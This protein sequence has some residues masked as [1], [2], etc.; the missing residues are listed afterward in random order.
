[1]K[2][3]DLLAN[4]PEKCDSSCYRCLRAFGNRI[5]HRSLDRHVGVELINYLL[6]GVVPETEAGRLQL[7]A[8]LLFKDLSRLLG[9]GT[10]IECE[11]N[12]EITVDGSNY[13]APIMCRLRSKGALLVVGLSS[14][15]KE[16]YA[17]DADVRALQGQGGDIEVVVV[18]ELLARSNLPAA[19]KLVREML[20]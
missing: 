4:C 9:G 2:A 19:T 13:T 10:E 3:R 1:M 17:A 6:T 16:G 11:R 20:G 7:S 8:D 15:L 18:N 14:A 5:E 12:A